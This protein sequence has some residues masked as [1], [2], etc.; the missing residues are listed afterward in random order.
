VAPDI[1]QEKRVL[2][3]AEARLAQAAG[4]EMWTTTEV[5]MNEHGPLAPIWLQAI[6]QRSQVT[7]QEGTHRQCLF[8]ARLGKRDQ[9]RFMESSL[10]SML[11]KDVP[12]SE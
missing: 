4:F 8:D 12:V 10:A 5:L 2:R 7:E 9:Q 1:S 3:V 11:L 6:P